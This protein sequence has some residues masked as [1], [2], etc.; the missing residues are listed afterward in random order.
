MKPDNRY[1]LAITEVIVSIMIYYLITWEIAPYFLEPKF[2][3]IVIVWVGAILGAYYILYISPKFHSDLRSSRGLG[4]K[5]T[6]FIRIDN[7]R[8]SASAYLFF[9]LV[10]AMIF[11][12]MIYF[13]Y[14]SDW[15]VIDPKDFMVKYLF[16]FL[17]AIV[18]D[19]LFFS[20]LFLRLKFLVKSLMDNAQYERFL[21]V[22]IF[23]L[24]FSLFHYP[25]WSLMI[26]TYS[27]AFGLGWIFYAKPNLF[28][29]VIIHSLFGVL[30]HRVYQLHMKI[31][32]FYGQNGSE[33][34]F[35]RKIIVGAEALIGNSW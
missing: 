33:A 34:S 13:K 19:L 16:Y 6:L 27:F 4:K 10:A 20:F 5:E 14:G 3:Q 9:V 11:A 7:L 2:W 26:L 22:I 15:E 18:Q 23:A 32:Q 24:L 21:T 17:S 28:W 30:L 31:G 29:V 1:R 8:T 25:N 35:F 12:V